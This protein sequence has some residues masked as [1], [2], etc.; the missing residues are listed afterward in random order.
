MWCVS[1]TST[2]CEVSSARIK[3]HPRLKYFECLVRSELLSAVSGCGMQQLGDRVC[4]CVCVCVSSL[5]LRATNYD[6]LDSKQAGGMAVT[7]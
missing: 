5:S 6:F 4:A 7:S 1:T 2:Q 3:R